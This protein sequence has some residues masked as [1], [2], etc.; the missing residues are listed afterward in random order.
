MDHSDLISTENFSYHTSEPLLLNICI[1][2]LKFS[3]V[4]LNI[5]SLQID[6]S[7]TV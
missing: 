5:L 3:F 2:C 4:D 6:F 7:L 1:Y